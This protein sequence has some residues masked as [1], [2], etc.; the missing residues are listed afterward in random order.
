M[1]I[2]VFLYRLAAHVC[3]ICSVCILVIQILDWYNP[4]MDFMGH[5]MFLLYILCFSAIWLSIC[6][7]FRLKMRKKRKKE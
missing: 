5:A 7:I 2:T 3:R 4:Y 6:S 1:K